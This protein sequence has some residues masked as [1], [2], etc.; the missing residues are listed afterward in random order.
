MTAVMSET[1][2]ETAT[3][4]ETAVNA[5]LRRHQQ[6]A[7]SQSLA[8]LTPPSIICANNIRH[9]ADHAHPKHPVVL[10]AHP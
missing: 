1:T 4:T 7:E 6:L 2:T 8:G 5:R 10:L 3:A 9:Y